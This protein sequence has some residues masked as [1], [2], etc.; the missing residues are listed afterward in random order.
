MDFIK[1]QTKHHLD[2]KA[3]LT[4]AVLRAGKWD[5]NITEKSLLVLPQTF[6]YVWDHDTDF[7][8]MFS[9]E[10]SEVARI[11]H[12]GSIQSS[13]IKADLPATLGELIRVGSIND[14]Q[15]HGNWQDLL[16]NAFALYAGTTKTWK[17]AG[18][19]KLGGH[20]IVSRYHNKRTGVQSVRPS[21][22]GDDGHNRPI[23]VK[24]FYELVN[25]VRDTDFSRHP[26]WFE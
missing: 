10:R 3:V 8:W 16:P 19:L 15:R 7:I 6:G 14:N 18:E 26:E 11:S 5:V 12:E 9:G 4:K 13:S 25:T 24:D 23:D 22:L 17:L 20:F 2:T 1:S 21:Y